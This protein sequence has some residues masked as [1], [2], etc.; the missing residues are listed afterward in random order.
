M[1]KVGVKSWMKESKCAC[2]VPRRVC[3]HAEKEGGRVYMWRHRMV[4]AD[5]QMVVVV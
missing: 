3:M 2:E 1:R 5:V 4:E